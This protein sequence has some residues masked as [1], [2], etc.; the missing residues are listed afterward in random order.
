M[1][2]PFTIIFFWCAIIAASILST[3]NKDIPDPLAGLILLISRIFIRPEDPK[4]WRYAVK[5]FWIG[6][7]LYSIGILF[8][9]LVTA[10]WSLYIS[11][12]LLFAGGLAILIWLGYIIFS[13]IR[14]LISPS[15]QAEQG[16]AANP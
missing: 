3:V 1:K 9:F 6:I 4:R 2:I 15:K 16:A 14:S 13:D 10:S 12:P 7:G 5:S 11:M 8:M